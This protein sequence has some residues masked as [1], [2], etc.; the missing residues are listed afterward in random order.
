MNTDLPVASPLIQ[1]INNGYI[2]SEEN[3]E[4]SAE[5]VVGFHQST[6]HRAYREILARAIK[7]IDNVVQQVEVTFLNSSRLTGL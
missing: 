2:P 6:D 3:Y 4:S 7:E 1:A 5:E